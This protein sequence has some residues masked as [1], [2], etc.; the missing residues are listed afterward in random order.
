LTASQSL[1]FLR[2]RAAADFYST[3]RTLMLHPTTVAV[4]IILDPYLFNILPRS[5]APNIFLVIVV[6]ICAWPLSGM[7]WRLLR[8]IAGAQ[9]SKKN[10]VE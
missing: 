10:H 3:N 9:R 5:L 2:V 1:L 8:D 7:T 4:D 6:A